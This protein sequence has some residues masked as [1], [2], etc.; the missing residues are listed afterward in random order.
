[1]VIRFRLRYIS[2]AVIVWMMCCGSEAWAWT[3][4]SQQAIAEQARA[5]APPDLA[6]QI[7]RHKVAFHSGVSQGPAIGSGEVG[8]LVEREAQRAIE[9]IRGHYPFADIVEQL[10]RIAYWVAYANNP[11]HA[12]SRSANYSDYLGYVDSARTRFRPVFYGLIPELE[13]SSSRLRTIVDRAQVR[14]RRHQKVLEMEY[15]RVGGPPGV[16]KFDDRSSAFGVSAVAFS[17]AVTDVG[18]A[19]RAIW[20]EAGGTD[21]R[22]LP[23]RH[24]VN[25]TVPLQTTGTTT[26]LKP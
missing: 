11:Y 6:H 14:G 24:A 2:T 17:H 21:Q 16:R 3:T 20:F 22:V 10:G 12:G 23:T 5:V 15:R 7:E 18:L 4:N 25:A 9:M 8:R 13:S 19:L 26:R 1:M